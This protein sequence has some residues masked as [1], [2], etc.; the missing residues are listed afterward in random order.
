MWE[1]KEC[2]AQCILHVLSWRDAARENRKV[3][4]KNMVSNSG[5]VVGNLMFSIQDEKIYTALGH[6][7]ADKSA[8]EEKIHRSPKPMDYL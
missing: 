4:V 3:A 2:R 5:F 7:N 6:I 1:L 8:T